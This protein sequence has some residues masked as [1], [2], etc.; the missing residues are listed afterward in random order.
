VSLDAVARVVVTGV[1]RTERL[2]TIGQALFGREDRVVDRSDARPLS[3]DAPVVH[4]D[5]QAIRPG[6]SRLLQG[7]SAFAEAW[8][9]G[10]EDAKAETY[11][12]VAVTRLDPE[13]AMRLR[14]AEA[15]AVRA[16][17]MGAYVSDATWAHHRDARYR[18][19]VSTCHENH[20]HF[21]P[22]DRCATCGGPTAQAPAP[23]TGRVHTCTVI[24]QGGGPSEFDFLQA[25][26]GSYASIVVEPD[27]LDGVRIPG[28]LADTPGESI[29]I[30]APVEA[31]FRR[32]YGMQGQW[33]YGMKFRSVRQ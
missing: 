4:V 20:S 1:S 21:P 10:S 15:E 9:L 24:S 32:I 27:G 33:R 5:V 16:L 14:S 2:P 19:L 31:V 28:I 23:R 17:P 11:E 29:A 30:G 26:W 3:G 7:A 25:A 18:L 8:L 22:R 12:P 6:S 13:T